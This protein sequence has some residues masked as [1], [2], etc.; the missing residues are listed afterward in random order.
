[1]IHVLL[2]IN[3]Q[4]ALVATT[5][6]V[7]LALSTTARFALPLAALHA[8]MATS[9]TLL[10]SPPALRLPEVPSSRIAW[11]TQSPD[12][13]AILVQLE[14]LVLVQ[15]INT[16]PALAALVLLLVTLTMC[17]VVELAQS[18]PLL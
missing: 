14:L 5:R 1:M 10:L 7:A 13:D 6:L 3:A 18:L 9:L 4:P 17:P 2:P 8:R 11:P 12:L 15:L 16:P